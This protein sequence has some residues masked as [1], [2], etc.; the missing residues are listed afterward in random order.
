MQRTAQ[1][2]AEI[3]LSV[4]GTV[5]KDQKQVAEVL[6]DYFATI[7]DGIGGN[8]AL[9]KSMDDF[10]DHPSIQRIKQ[11]SE[12][13]SLTP[14]VKPVTQGQ[15][16]VALESL[17]TNKATGCDGIPAK[18]MK[19]GAKELSQP[20]TDLFNSCIH[21]S[22]WPS[23]WK[24]GDWTPVHKKDDKYS[25]ENYRPITVLPCVDKVFEQ[26][27][28]TQLTAGF[29]SHMYEYS[30]AYRKVHSCETTL[31][32]LVEGWRKAR[33]NKLAVSI[34]STDMSKAFDSLHPPL[35]LSKLKAYGFQDS[36]VQLLNSYLSNRKYRVKLG[37]HVSSHRTV[38]RGCPQ[39]SALGPLLWNIFQNDLSYCVTTN[40]SM[41]ADDHQ[42]YHTGCNQSSVTSKLRDSAR[43]AT[44][45]YDHNLLAGN[46]KKYQTMNIGYSQDNSAAHAICVNNE[47]I[48]SVES[49]NLL[50]VAIDSKLNFTDH[51]SSICKKASQRIGVIMR[52]RNLIPTKAKLVLFKSAILP[53]LTYCHLVWHFCR[54]SDAR[55]L[56]RLQE[57]GLR[58][59]YRDKISSYSQLLKRAELPTLMNRRLQDICILM[60]RVRNRLCPTYI[61]NIF[62]NHNSSYSL[63]QS[64]FSTPSFNTVTYGKHSLRYLG[65]K[66]WGKLSPDIRSAKTLN[67]FRKQIRKYDI[68]LL[69]DDGCKGCSLCSS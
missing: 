22:V 43:T 33:D 9:L 18:V 47:E 26:L 69:I 7:A 1:K 48:K 41:Y 57:R 54:S 32:N 29:D 52:L 55:K 27:V 24:H 40:L 62:N 49:L 25:K 36:T 37:N 68:S 64:D 5:V 11:E 51:I 10:K 28:G 53:Y 67:I 6:V 13:W 45:W 35:L 66:L 39:G 31:I 8:S 63:R 20:L 4:H 34:L 38:S 50:G 3:Q 16:L 46:L 60:Y 21:N 61:C 19:I 65:P 30:S 44:K 17:N 58:A 23:D 14:N 42:I 56:E 59:V 12:N 2:N 15:V